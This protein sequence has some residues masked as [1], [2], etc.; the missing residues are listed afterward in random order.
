MAVGARRPCPLCDRAPFDRQMRHTGDSPI[1]ALD[2]IAPRR[3]RK[4]FRKEYDVLADMG[5]FAN[6]HVE[7]LF[8][9]IVEMSPI[10]RQHNYVVTRL[11]KLL[12]LSLLDRAQVRIQQSFAALDDTEPEPDVSIVLVRQAF[13]VA[14]LPERRVRNLLDR[15]PRRRSERNVSLTSRRRIL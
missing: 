5:F 7:L 12:T 1:H 2:E 14:I 10:G 9:R 3:F 6:E 13:G 15:Q 11:N 8:G 4:L